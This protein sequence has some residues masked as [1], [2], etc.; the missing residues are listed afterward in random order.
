VVPAIPTG[1]VET[2]PVV[3]ADAAPAAANAGTTDTKRDQRPD[4][5]DAWRPSRSRHR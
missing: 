4:K 3:E 2:E 5:D 1:D